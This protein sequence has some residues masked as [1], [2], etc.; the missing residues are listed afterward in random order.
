MSTSAAGRERRVVVL[1][2]G[3]RFLRSG[4]AGAESPEF[5]DGA[6][7]VVRVPH[8][9]AIRGPFDRNHDLQIKTVVEDGE[10]RPSEHIARTG[11]LPHV[12]QGWYRRKFGVPPGSRGK[13]FFLEF[14]GVMANSRVYVNG[15]YVGSWPY[16]YSSFCF[17]ITDQVRFGAE[18]LLAVSLEVKPNASRWYPGAGIYRNVRLVVTGQLRVAHWGTWVTTP[19][20]R[21]GRAAVRVRTE[22]DSHSGCAEDAELETRILDDSG[23]EVARGAESVRVEGSAQVDQALEIESP[24]LW[25]PGSPR[26]YTALSSV[27]VGG[28]IVDRHETSFGIREFRF[29]SDEGFF[30]NGRSTKLKGVC[31]HHD[32]GPLGAAVNRRALE[33]Q[34]EI[35]VGMGCNAVRT[36]HNPPAPELLEL[37]DRMGLLVIDE[38]FDEWRLAKVENGYNLLFDDWV[39]RDLRAMIRRDRNHPCVIMW[40][41]GNEV[42]EQRSEDGAVVA[43]MLADICHQEDPTRPTTLGF[44]NQEAAIRNGL[45]DV[46]DVPGWNYKPE[47]YLEFH[48]DHPG[49]KV[50]GSETESCVSSRGVYHFP[51]EEVKRRQMEHESNHV[52]SYDMCSP[53]W[54]CAPDVGFAVQDDCPFSAG[55]FVWTGFDYLGEPTPYNHRWPSRSSYFGILDLCGFH[56]DRYYAY[57]SKWRPEVETLHLFPHWNWEGREGEVVP[58]HCYTSFRSAEL[59]LNGES[60]GVRRKDPGSVYDR[61]RLRWNDVRYQPGVLK[62]VALDEDARPVSSREV[63]TTGAAARIELRPDRSEIAA[64]GRDLSFITVRITDADG[65]VCPCAGNLVSFELDGPGRIAA[66]GSGDPT[67]LE[68][69]EADERRAFNGLCLL[70][71]K[72]AEK[73]SG[74]VKV[75]ATSPGLE[76]AEIAVSCV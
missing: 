59:F 5:D 60:Q 21:E 48:R 53:Q 68:P 66:V 70:I 14:D 6:W 26:L 3:W 8:D 55:E 42:P 9:W 28:E 63:R 10:K 2:S 58:V 74:R 13:R 36:S 46:V 39:E 37:C 32:L 67:S 18:N 30:L 51:V 65:R 7:D 43:R 34:L 41:I 49:W 40:S 56:K 22:L 25:S 16:G 54:G 23:A 71:V 20:I 27:S 35:L 17:E 75:R 24:A 64:D 29:D 45:P 52:S 4:V 50:Y 15:E 72:S 73:Q 12:G 19:E 1:E 61:Y 44:N 31:M 69:F 62:V 57:R 11:G 38:A 76:A 33:R 47:K